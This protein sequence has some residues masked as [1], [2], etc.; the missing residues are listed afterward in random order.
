MGRRWGVALGRR[1]EGTKGRRDEGTKGRRDKG[2]KG[3]RTKDKGTKDKGREGSWLMAHGS[4]MQYPVRMFED[5]RSTP[6]I[7]AHRGDS[8]RAADNTL[9][10]FELAVDAGAD[11][12]EL[13]VRRTA[14]GVLV[15]S[16]D[17]ATPTIGRIDRATFDMMRDLDP[18]VPTLEEALSEIPTGMLV[19]VE[20]KNSRAERGYDSELTI[21][22]AVTTELRNFANPD[23]FLI[24]SFDAATAAKAKESGPEFGTGLLVAEVTRL[25]TGLRNAASARHETINVNRRHLRKNAAEAV[26]RAR[27]MDLDVVVWTVDDPD[28]IH[29]LAVAGVSAIITNTPLGAR[30]VIDAL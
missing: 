25:A 24:T 3:Q 29:Q 16:H 19:N 23:R 7:Y 26:D 8:S 28:E 17:P 10:A 14:D 18:T 11:G 6:L 13:D 15:L 2:T 9:E 1:D 27:S 5:D 21:V 20:I 4:S 12:I 22:D 30:K